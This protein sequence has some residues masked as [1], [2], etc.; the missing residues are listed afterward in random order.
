[1]RE[2]IS[3]I[4]A[5][6][7]GT[8]LAVILAQNDKEVELHSVFREHNRVMS[9]E[10]MNR[11]FLKGI[12][13]PPLLKIN[14]SLRSVLNNKIIILAV[15]VKFLKECLKKIKKLNINFKDKIFVSVAKGI[16]VSSLKRPSEIIQE[17]LG[18]VKIA[19]LSGPTIAK[20]VVKGIPTTCIVASKNK[21]IAKRVQ[22]AL[23]TSRFR[24]YHHYDV[25][26]VELAGALKNIIAIAC[27]VSDGLGFG[28]NT[29]AALLSRGLVEIVRLGK[30]M[31]ACPSTFWGISGLGDLATTCFSPYSRNRFVGEQIGKGRKLKEI[32]NKM[33]MIAE[34]INTVYSAYILSKKMKIEM[35][36]TS[37]VYKVL[38]R[39][40]KPH[41]AVNDL[42][43]RP[44]K[45]ETVK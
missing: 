15:P 41:D 26:G 8:T 40:K 10:R 37:E 29:K 45:P 14:D 28:T 32:L 20:E 44:L 7:W 11:L 31:G 21:K 16:E 4:G 18:N 3:I 43:M 36:I 30:K 5:G 24:I 42:M 1:M 25:L 35:P 27:G 34:G 33:E 2:R 6:S 38:Y 12:K 39:N 23:S 9:K 13:F 19:V 22:Y 17:Q